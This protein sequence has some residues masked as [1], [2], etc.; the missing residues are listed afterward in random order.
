[1]A[2]CVSTTSVSVS[3][4]GPSSRTDPPSTKSIP[5]CMQACMMP[6][7]STPCSTAL[8]MEPQRRMV[9]IARMWCS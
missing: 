3:G 1:M 9:L 8:A 6:E 7:V 2:R 5:C 4:S